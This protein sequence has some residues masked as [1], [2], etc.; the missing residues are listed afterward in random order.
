MRNRSDETPRW[1][2]AHSGARDNYQLPI[3]LHESGQLHRFVTDWYSPMDSPLLVPLLKYAPQRVRSTLG[4]RFRADLPSRLVEDLKLKG[5]LKAVFGTDTLDLD[6]NRL[7]GER[8]ARI[9]A[10]SGSQLLVTSYYGWAAFP[11][12]AK[13]T[14]KILFQIHPHPWFLRDLYGRRENEAEVV[15]CFRNE[16]E[17]KVEDR[18][19]RLWGQESLDADLVIAASSFTRQSLLY[20][21]VRPERIVVFPYG[22]DNRI[23]RNDVAMP[24]GKAKIL[25]V[26]QAISRKGF[27][28]L[29]RTWKRIGNRR[30]ELHVVSGTAAQCQETDSG[31]VVWH[32][33]L[34]LTDLVALMNRVDLL[35]LPSIAEGFGHVLLQA[36]SCG[37]PILCSD[38]TAGPDLLQGWE[39]GFIFSSEDWNEFASRLDFWLTN[40]DR[41]RRLRKAARTL[42]ESL[43]WEMFREGVRN[44]C[45]LA[46]QVA[47]I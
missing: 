34:S 11:Q 26:G 32:D 29:L 41:L 27:H 23:F 46:E 39:E 33:H 1:V 14:T 19:L 31:N 10:T 9:A 20:A 47:R 37:T 6:L 25:F 44:A 36:L 18:F 35:V 16:S 24:S 12:L 40:V 7:V 28:H 8:A 38:A 15:D 42:A 2:V 21:G 5:V 30:A 17:M 43:P 22:V 3:A 45:S 13:R 4:K